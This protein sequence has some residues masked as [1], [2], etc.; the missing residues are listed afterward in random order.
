MLTPHE[1]ERCLRHAAPVAGA[2]GAAAHARAL[3]YVLSLTLM[4]TALAAGDEV[5]ARYAGC[6]S[7]GWCRLWIEPPHSASQTLYRIRPEGVPYAF[8]GNATA[9]SVRDRLNILLASMI[10]QHK[11][12]VVRAIHDLDDGT[13]AATVLVNGSDVASDLVLQELLQGAVPAER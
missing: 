8:G 11:R 10:H 5:E 1:P 4:H 13:H 7:A 2:R 9:P 12:I 3:L 6:D